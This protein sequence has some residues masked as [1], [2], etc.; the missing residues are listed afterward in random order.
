MLAV[1][2]YKRKQKHIQRDMKFLRSEELKTERSVA[3]LRYIT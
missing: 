3:T 2:G 1:F